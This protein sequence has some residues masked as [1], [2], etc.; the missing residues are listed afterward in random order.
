MF[1]TALY[2]GRRRELFLV[3]VLGALY[4]SQFRREWRFF[5]SEPPHFYNQ[6][7]NGFEFVYG[8][9]RNP[10]VFSR[11]FIASEVIQAGDVLLDIGC[12]DGFFTNA[13]YSFRCLRIDAIDVEPSAIRAAKE[14]N[15]AP[16]IS[17]RHA[18][19]VL[20]PFPSD[21]YDVV[22]WDGAIG[23]FSEPDV[24]V[25]LNKI[26]RVLSSM[27]VFVGSE[28]LGKEGSDHLQFFEDESALAAVFRPY[29]KHVQIRTMEYQ[30]G[31][32]FL[33]KEAYWRC[34]NSLGHR[35]GP[36]AWTEFA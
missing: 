26:T 17:Y 24:S 21:R 35:H 29:F 11:G 25:V 28:S 1:E 33:R 3:C 6:R 31:N 16:N 12:G 20:D 7:W 2:G 36:T 13:F 22:V 32:G 30:L 23:H 9:A 5:P 14:L 10:Y 27:G 18:D 4:R 34:A 8:S 19:A 15:G